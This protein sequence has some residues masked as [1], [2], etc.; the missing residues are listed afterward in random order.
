MKKIILILVAALL[1]SLCACGNSESAPSAAP[2]EAAT[3]PIAVPPPM[4]VPQAPVAETEEAA[5]SSMQVTEILPGGCIETPNFIMTF[6]SLEI[7]DE[8]SYRTSEY[9][10]TSL[11]V[12]Q[13]YKLLMIKGHFDNVGTSTISDSAFL[14]KAVVNDGFEVEGFD[15]RINFIRDKYFEIDPYTDLDYVLYINIPEKLADMFETV[16]FTLSFND[17]M[18]IPTTIWNMDGTKTHDADNHY[19]LTWD[20]G[21]PADGSAASKAP[22]TSAEPQVDTISIGE[23]IVTENYE[24]TLLKVETTYEL[25]PPNTSSVYTS[26]PAESGKV[27]IHV[28]ADVKNTMPR[29]IRIDELFGSGALY[30]GKYSYTGFTVVN[31]GDNAFD[32]VGSY[33]A[34]IPL[35][36]CRAHALIECPAE[37]DTSGKSIVVT[38]K[39]GDSTYEYVLR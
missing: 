6:D 32:W 28:E 26:Y 3:E 30:D 29:D 7:L 2:T 37:V 23:T 16:T 9:S 4:E 8:Y 22:E 11:Y 14:R 24:F 33:V 35:E 1:L 13:G 34:A 25:L 31:D 20:A 12:E 10:T 21:Q 15:V 19:S 36:V 17:D 18:S 5:E 27:Y 38:L 39:L